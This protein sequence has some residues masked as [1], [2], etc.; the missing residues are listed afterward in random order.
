MDEEHVRT[1]W[2]LHSDS[3]ARHEVLNEER[4]SPDIL[5]FWPPKTI[6]QWIRERNESGLLNDFR[7]PQQQNGLQEV[8]RSIAQ[9]D[10]RKKRLSGDEYVLHVLTL[11]PFKQWVFKMQRS[12][13]NH[14]DKL[15]PQMKHDFGENEESNEALDRIFQLVLR[16][17]SVA[18]VTFG[19]LRVLCLRLRVLEFRFSSIRRCIANRDQNLQERLSANF[20]LLDRVMS[21][22]PVL[23]AKMLSEQLRDHFQRLRPGDF[24]AN[25]DLCQKLTSIFNSYAIKSRECMAAGLQDIISR[26]SKASMIQ[27]ERY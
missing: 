5:A 10:K 26:V 7:L 12:P 25:T 22:E 13:E 23:M 15:W 11:L 4:P 17:I 27:E 16:S 6:N 9:T 18:F 19:S 1:A 20:D 3:L 24:L 14:V 2:I 8:E 21:F